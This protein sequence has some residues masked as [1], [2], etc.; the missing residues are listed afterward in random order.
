M[1]MFRAVLAALLILPMLAWADPAE[2]VGVLDGDT[3]A[4]LSPDRKMTR[5]RL[6]G[7]DAP[8]KGQ[9]FGQASK[10]A[11]SDLIYRKTLDVRVVDTDR[12][13][14]AVCRLTLAGV[15]TAVP[16]RRS[17]QPRRKSVKGCVPTCCSSRR[18]TSAL[19][20]RGG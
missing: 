20:A 10:K 1:T 4:V 15:V 5:C 17:N 19:R 9:A 12:Y 13:G 2:V 7:I 3:V 6:F 14:R 8:E 16:R 11:L 18:A